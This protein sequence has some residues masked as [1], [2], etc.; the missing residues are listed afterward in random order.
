MNVESVLIDRLHMQYSLQLYQW[1]KALL[2]L[3]IN[4]CEKPRFLANS[5]IA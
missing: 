5:Q 4:K 3:G 1:I 2:F